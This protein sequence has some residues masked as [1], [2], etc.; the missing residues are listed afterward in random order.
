MESAAAGDEIVSGPQIQV[1]GVAEEDLRAER[2]ELAMRH[3]LH[4]TLRTDRHER[5]RLD[6]AMRRRHA[7]AAGAGVGVG[8]VESEG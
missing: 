3:A 5:R 8:Q 2:V 1:I 6:D 7:A 4:R